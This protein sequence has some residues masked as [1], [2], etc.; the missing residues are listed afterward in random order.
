MQ[1]RHAAGI[2][3]GVAGSRVGWRIRD[4]GIFATKAFAQQPLKAISAITIAVPVQIIPPHLINHKANY[5]LWFG[6]ALRISGNQQ[7]NKQEQEYPGF[8]HLI[9]FSK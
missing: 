7:A 8:Y 4:E 5:Q 1:R 2:N 9:H 3:A 6:A